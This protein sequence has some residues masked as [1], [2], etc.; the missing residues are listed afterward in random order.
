[1]SRV[2]TILH[3]LAEAQR[4]AWLF[5]TLDIMAARKLTSR[6]IPLATA[7]ALSISL[8]AAHTYLRP[9][10]LDAAPVES[11]VG[12]PKKAKVPVTPAFSSSPYTP[13]GWGS[14]R[15]LTLSPDSSSSQI[16]R[17]VPLGQFGATPLRDMV[18]SEKYGA[19]VDARGDCWMWGVG[20]DE[21]GEIGRSLKGKVSFV[22]TQDCL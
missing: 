1:M 18:L 16:K 10:L 12:L 22:H 9:V 17:P 4:S 8:Y 13:L 2:S 15:Y 19:A 7:T 11:T 6:T 5:G 3:T 14:N 21:S 20:Y